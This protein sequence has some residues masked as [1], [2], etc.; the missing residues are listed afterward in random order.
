MAIKDMVPWKKS[1][2]NVLVRRHDDPFTGFRDEMD[3]LF[4]DFFGRGFGLT[5]F[6]G[7]AMDHFG[8]FNP[9]VDVTEND[10]EVKITAEL[11]GL[12]EQDVEVSLSNDVL[13]ISGEKKHEKEDKGDNYYRMERSYGSFQRT[14]PL[15]AE[16]QS[17]KVDASFKN[18]VLTIT[19]PKSPQATQNR[20]KIAIKAS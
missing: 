18:G 7:G 4:D 19:L 2:K 6:E 13:T 11:P 20:K 15:P 17:D 8:T 1:D 9:Q 14:I 5:P 16:V 10:K 3:R 12:S